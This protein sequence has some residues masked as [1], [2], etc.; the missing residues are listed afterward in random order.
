[1]VAASCAWQPGLTT[2]GTEKKTHELLLQIPEVGQV[3]EEQAKRTV[4]TLANSPNLYLISQE[5]RSRKGGS[6]RPPQCILY[7]YDSEAPWATVDVPEAG[8]V[9]EEDWESFKRRVW[10]DPGSLTL[11]VWHHDQ[12]ITLHTLDKSTIPPPQTPVLLNY[13]DCY[14]LRGESFH[15]S[16]LVLGG[17]AQ[18]TVA[19][20]PAGLAQGADGALD[21]H[22]PAAALPRQVTFAM[23]ITGTQQT[24]HPC[25]VKFQIQLG[26]EAPIVAM[27]VSADLE[28]A[29]KFLANG[30]TAGAKLPLVPLKSR[31]YK[32]DRPIM[33]MESGLNDYLA[34]RMAD[35]SLDLL[36]LK[37]LK[38][39][40]SIKLKDTTFAFMAGDVVFTYDSETRQLT[41]H[42]LP[43][44]T[45]TGRFQMPGTAKFYG[46]G[47]GVHPAGPLTVLI[48]EKVL[49]NQP[50]Y[51]PTATAMEC[52]AL[53]LDKQTLA[54][55]KWAPYNGQ[56]KPGESTSII[57]N[58]LHGLRSAPGQIP[59]SDNGRLLSFP[60]GLVMISPALSVDF[61]YSKHPIEVVRAHLARDWAIDH[62][63]SPAA[64]ASPTG[65][66]VFWNSAMYFNNYPSFDIGTW[67]DGLGVSRC[68]NYVAGLKNE[69]SDRYNLRL[70]SADDGRPLLNLAGLDLLKIEDGKQD[71][72]HQQLCLLGDKNQVVVLSRGGKLLQVV[73][74]DLAAACQT[75]NP[76]S[77]Y[78]TSHPFPIVA[79]GRVFSY[80][81][82]VN[83][84][85]V[86]SSYEL[87]DQVPGASI[88]AQG[89]LTYQAPP[90]LAESQ[91][92]NI[93]ILIRFKNGETALHQFPIYTI[94]L[95]PTASGG[96]A[97]IK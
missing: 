84:P 12:T 25:E 5:I 86:V 15:F 42:A 19:D 29:G 38:V 27:P 79:A 3:P 85:A 93:P 63:S 31:I 24:Q 64:I 61:D 49:I 40:G 45:L 4:G 39:A 87:R 16:P 50:G 76:D 62:Q 14:A 21:W 28:A 66:R 96:K 53:V 10:L 11:A 83:N 67:M 59:T 46:L 65:G 51:L 54:V 73:D 55:G 8:D 80:Q 72:K 22:V 33:R 75:I 57:Q 26:G 20:A 60:T 9:Q 41:R 36:S 13:P 58:I 94:A 6:S 69:N 43:G 92:I 18:L 74:F 44:F 78:V 77:A 56:R 35:K 32:T 81:V 88:D 90:Q 34:L 95:K 70:F 23:K 17:T 7:S 71:V 2:P 48:E 1:M 30:T 52:F 37:D 89:L 97:P 91:Q 68:G 82:T 47:V